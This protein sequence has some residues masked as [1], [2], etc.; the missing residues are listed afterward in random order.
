MGSSSSSQRR[1]RHGSALGSPGPG[2]VSAGAGTV[3][4]SHIQH[5]TGSTS[6]PSGGG[7]TQPG[8]Q[9][10]QAPP[11]SHPSTL[12]R[13]PPQQQSGPS[14]TVAGRGDGAAPPPQGPGG[15][16][17]PY[18]LMFGGGTQGNRGASGGGPMIFYVNNQQATA[19]LPE[20]QESVKIKNH[21]NLLKH[22]LQLIPHNGRSQFRIGFRCDTLV[23]CNVKLY[24][25][26]CETVENGADGLLCTFTPENKSL[27]NCVVPAVKIPAETDY[28]FS[29]PAGHPYDVAAYGRFLKYNSS[30]PDVYPIIIAL[31]YEVPAPPSSDGP[32]TP[33]IQSQYTYAEV[34]KSDSEDR[35]LLRC[36]KQRLQLGDGSLFDLDDIYGVAPEGGGHDL[37]AGSSEAAGGV[38]DAT[39]ADVGVEGDECVI[40]LANERDTTVMPCRHMCLC[41][42]CA[43]VLRRQTNKCPIC[44]TVI[45]RLMTLKKN[46]AAA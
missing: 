6:Q 35:Y 9:H 30:N 13:P 12:S 25:W 3:G 18:Y 45:E 5:R 20:V 37:G 43:E 8:T 7:A 2:T 22:T 34:T 40:C 44:R 41:S 32:S 24:F 11:Q 38:V 16:Q 15:G 19:P 39:V 27:P 14:S 46:P 26:A 33:K 4:A 21:A 42:E 23:E 28:A 1:R 31:S 17:R 29:S 36:I 10:R